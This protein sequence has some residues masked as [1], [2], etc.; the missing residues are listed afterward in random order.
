MTDKSSLIQ[1][2]A[3]VFYEEHTNMA[4]D[5]KGKRKALINYTHIVS[6][7]TC[8][9][10]RVGSSLTCLPGFD[11]VHERMNSVRKHMATDAFSGVHF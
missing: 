8:Q 5:E 6:R 1:E 4:L 2:E 3:S 10:V 7:N 9:E 11:R